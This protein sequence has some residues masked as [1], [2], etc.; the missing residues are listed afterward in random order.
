MLTLL[1]GE[2]FVDLICQRPVASLAEVDAFTPHL[3]GVSATVA[4]GAARQGAEVALAGGVG[5]D[6][7][8]DWVRDRLGREGVNLDRLRAV[9][10]TVTPVAFVT[11]DDDAEPASTV[12]GDPLRACAEGIG[13]GVDAAVDA[14]DAVVLAAGT[15]AAERSAELTLAARDRAAAQG[16]P[17]VVE[18]DLQLHRWESPIRAAS[19]A[20]ALVKGAFLVT[21]DQTHARL[22]SGEERPEAAADGLLAMGAQHVVVRVGAHGALVR[23]RNLKLDVSARTPPSPVSRRGA[24][25]AFTGVVLG[26]LAATGYYPPAIAAALPDAVA[27][28]ARA[29]ERWA[30]LA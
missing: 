29:T 4:A 27:E 23:G 1:L 17:I 16:K 21:C 3:G 7:W 14:A 18:A 2:A 13:D 15:L 5:A 10:R 28:A 6:P 26:R 8:G 22:L 19:E 24:D 20:R 30:A 9:A 12:Y 11:V 25:A